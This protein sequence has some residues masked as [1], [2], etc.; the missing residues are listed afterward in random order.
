MIYET[1]EHTLLRDQVARFLAAE[2]EP[3]GAA[4]EEAGA[5]AARRAAPDGRRWACSG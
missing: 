3:H 2:V 5:H 1:S 4:W